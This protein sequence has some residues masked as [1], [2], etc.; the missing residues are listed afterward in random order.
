MV[1]KIMRLENAVIAPDGRSVEF[2]L[3]TDESAVHLLLDFDDLP[4]L[5][6]FLAI[7][8][9]HAPASDRLPTELYPYGVTG[10]GVQD[11][12]QPD[13]TILLANLGPSALALEMPRSELIG[14]ARRLLLAASAPES[15]S[16]PN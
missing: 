5:V 10:L 8:A 13:T 1:E 12:A 9:N 11:G 6:Q 15:G 14:M 2:T 3:Q 7:A 16:Q 4:L